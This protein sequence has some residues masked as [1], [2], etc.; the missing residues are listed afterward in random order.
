MAEQQLSVRGAV[1][2]VQ[3]AVLTLLE[4]AGFDE[5][6]D[7]ATLTV[8]LNFR[9][10]RIDVARLSDD[11]LHLGE[12]LCGFSIDPNDLSMFGTPVGLPTDATL[13]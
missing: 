11:G 2:T 7:L 10:G 6:T 1:A 9:V 12:W 8:N 5:H 13:Q 4:A 3:V